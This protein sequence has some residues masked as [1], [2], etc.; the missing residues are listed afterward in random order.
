MAIGQKME[1]LLLRV[2]RNNMKKWLIILLIIFCKISVGVAQ[3][4]VSDSLIIDHQAE[5]PGGMGAFGKFLQKNLRYPQALQKA[6]VPGKIYVK[7]SVETDGTL[8]NYN[9]IKSTGFGLDEEVIK[10]LK[11]SPKW[12]PAKRKGKPVRSDFILPIPCIS[13]SE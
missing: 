12:I 13:I 3:S 11:L 10:V 9:V 7:F 2:K 6:N 8:A 5:F 4:V 1:S